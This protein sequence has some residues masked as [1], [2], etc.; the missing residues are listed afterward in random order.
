M[1]LSWSLQ[2]AYTCEKQPPKGGEG[3]PWM[4]LSQGICPL[5]C[6]SSPAISPPQVSHI[7]LAGDSHA[8]ARV[9]RILLRKSILTHNVGLGACITRWCSSQ[10]SSDP[11]TISLYSSL[12]S[13]C[14]PLWNVFASWSF[15]RT[16]ALGPLALAGV[17]C[18]RTCPPLQKCLAND[19]QGGS[20]KAHP[21]SL[22]Q[23]LRPGLYSRVSLWGQVEATC[24][25]TYASHPCWVSSPVLLPPLSYRFLPR[26]LLEKLGMYQMYQSL[27]NPT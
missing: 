8:P 18:W 17:E 21:L 27:G 2:I 9:R 14:V 7:S 13:F 26:A 11:F 16:T 15:S 12:A 4:W 10:S 23:T 1:L 3:S 6:P 24:S 20:L 19:W 5:P 25:G 22:G